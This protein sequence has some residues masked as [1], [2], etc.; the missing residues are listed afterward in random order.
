M[1][2]NY[3]SDA[4]CTQVKGEIKTMSDDTLR[5]RMNSD[6]LPQTL[7]E[8]VL[9]IKDQNWQQYPSGTNW[10]QRFRIASYNAYSEY[11][12]NKWAEVMGLGYSFGDLTNPTG[13][14]AQDGDNILIFV[15][16]DVPTDAALEAQFVPL[17]SRTGNNCVL[18]KDLNI[19]F[20]R[21]ENNIFIDYIGKTFG[22]GKALKDF[23]PLK[24]HIEGG[25][26]NGYFDLTKDDTNDD[27]RKYTPLHLK[28]L[29]EIWRCGPSRG[30]YQVTTTDGKKVKVFT[31][32][33]RMVGNSLNGLAKGFVYR[34]WEK[35][36]E[37]ISSL[38]LTN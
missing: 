29:V 24:V 2:S 15:G 9:K 36:N 32:G 37:I 10:E 6:G 33:G 31:I 25:K 23:S 38:Y 7:Q 26:V 17:G 30:V 5:Q 1:M 35:D 34:K 11:D 13:I 19:I 14:T 27:Y 8:V 20:N 21:A 12:Q 16:D 4:T 3:F 22:T 28:E 18:K